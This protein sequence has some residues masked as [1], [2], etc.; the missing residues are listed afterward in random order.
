[1]RRYLIAVEGDVKPPRTSSDHQE[2]MALAQREAAQLFQAFVQA[3]D[4]QPIYDFVEG[5]LSITDPC[6]KLVVWAT[7]MCYAHRTP[8]QAYIALMRSVPGRNVR[9]GYIVMDHTMPFKEVFDEGRLS[10]LLEQ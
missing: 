9:M 4:M 5:D 7:L 8:E 2:R 6:P 1:M 10:A 3:T